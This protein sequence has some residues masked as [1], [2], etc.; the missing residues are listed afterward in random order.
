MSWKVSPRKVLMVLLMCMITVYHTMTMLYYINGMDS[1]FLEKRYII[2]TMTMCLAI[3]LV[4]V[5]KLNRRLKMPLGIGITLMLLFVF[6]LITAKLNHQYIYH[7]VIS[8]TLMWIPICAASYYSTLYYGRFPVGKKIIWLLHNLFTTVFDKK[9]LSGFLINLGRYVAGVALVG[10]IT[11][12]IC[13]RISFSNLWLTLVIRGLISC[14]I[15]N[16]VF[17]GLYHRLREFKECVKLVDKMTKG[18]F[19]LSGLILG[20]K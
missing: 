11:Y 10:V 3:L 14:L 19:R 8:Q 5:F 9:Y 12:L 15:P 6:P 20:E 7:T 4:A 18:K 1:S 2:G 17:W 13:N 16:V